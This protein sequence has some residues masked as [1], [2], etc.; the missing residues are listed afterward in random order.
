MYKLHIGRR[1]ELQPQV[2]MLES[3]LK[4]RHF[5]HWTTIGPSVTF[6]VRIAKVQQL[7]SYRYIMHAMIKTPL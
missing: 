7:I 1:D 6:Q 4:E 2:I 5:L 3:E